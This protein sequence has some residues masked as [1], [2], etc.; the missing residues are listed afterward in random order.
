MRPRHALR[1][2]RVA[3]DPIGAAGPSAAIQ[4]PAAGWPSGRHRSTS[5]AG[6]GASAPQLTVSPK[7]A[8]LELGRE[9][10]RP[11]T[12]KSPSA[13]RRWS[14]P[15]DRRIGH[16]L[17]RQLGG[18]AVGHA[19]ADGTLAAH[20]LQ[21]SG[22][23]TY[24]YDVRLS[25]SRDGGKTWAASFTPHP[26]GTK[27]EHG[28]ASL[29]QIPGGRLG[30]VWLDGRAMKPGRGEHGGGDM[31]LR[32]AASA[33]TGSRPPTRRWISRLRM[34]P[35]CVG[36]DLRRAIVAYRDR[37]AGE[38]RDIHITRLDKGKWSDRRPVARRTGNSPRAR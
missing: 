3:L 13:P 19:S 35:H 29:F 31:S 15:R 5:P 2:R 33:A 38:I 22:A 7:G 32:F 18:R 9:G 23:G 20:W 6:A 21:K 27:T 17:V 12:L 25:S 8:L 24:A 34:L 14:T 28:F 30:V 36:G 16:R 10:R 26:D 4:Q 1:T 11:A 37:V